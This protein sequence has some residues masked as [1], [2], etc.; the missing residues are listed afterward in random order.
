MNCSED[1]SPSTDIRQKTS[2]MMIVTMLFTSI[3]FIN[4]AFIVSLLLA[5]MFKVVYPMTLHFYYIF[6]HSCAFNEVVVFVN[7]LFKLF[8]AVIGKLYATECS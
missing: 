3:N 8:Y 6:N 4:F 2:V 5:L 7:F 1:I